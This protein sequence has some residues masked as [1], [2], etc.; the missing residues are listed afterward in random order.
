MNTN[1]SDITIKPYPNCWAHHNVRDAVLHLQKHH[2]IRAD[3]VD[4]V[5]VDLQPDKPTYR[6][7][8]P[9]TDLEARYSLRYGIALCLLDGTLGLD[10]FADDRITD[11][12]TT[13]MLSGVHHAPQALGAAQNEVVIVLTDGRRLAHRVE[14]SK[15]H[16]RF[17]PMSDAEV[18]D[19]FTGCATRLLPEAQAVRAAKL[20][21]T[22]VEVSDMAL[23]MDALVAPS[24]IV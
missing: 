21:N 20:I 14:H 6:Y 24:A 13:E 4:C 17:N 16:P 7:L 5:E 10:Q 8:A 1:G 22:L 12:R 19:K 3:P 11:P 15:G 2:D 9:K 23:V 18:Q